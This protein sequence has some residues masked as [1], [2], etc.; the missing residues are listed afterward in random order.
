MI[1]LP[2]AEE[3]GRRLRQA[4]TLEQGGGEQLDERDNT[5]GK[6]RSGTNRTGIKKADPQVGFFN[7]QLIILLVLRQLA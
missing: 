3:P 6:R 5:D 4:G 1:G 2:S 7:N